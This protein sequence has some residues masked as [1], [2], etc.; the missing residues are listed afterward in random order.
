[1]SNESSHRRS[2]WKLSATSLPRIAAVRGIAVY[3]AVISPWLG[4]H[5]RFVP[6]CSE[7]M[8]I[9]IERH[10]LF[11]GAWQGLRRLA[12]CHPFHRGGLDPV[13]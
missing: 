8:V 7:Y 6:S 13:R 2:A 10:G 11:R 5:C 1:M 9:S 3:Q 12:R 4:P